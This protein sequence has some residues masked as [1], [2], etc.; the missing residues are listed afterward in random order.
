MHLWT[1]GTLVGRQV[2]RAQWYTPP[3]RKDVVAIPRWAPD[4]P[5]KKNPDNWSYDVRLSNRNSEGFTRK[6]RNTIAPTIGL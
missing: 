1:F 6:V 2:S 5:F 4:L 3:N